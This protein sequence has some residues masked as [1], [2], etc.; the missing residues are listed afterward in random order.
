[1]GRWTRIA[2][3]RFKG[4]TMCERGDFGRNFVF[5]QDNAL[6]HVTRDT[7]AFLD[8]ND[9][10]EMDWSAMRSDMNPLDHV[11]NE[12]SIWLPDKD[13]PP[14]NLFELRQAA[15]QTWWAVRARRVWTLAESIP[16]SKV[17]VANM[18]PTWGRQDPGGP[19]VGSM[20][21]AIGDASLCAG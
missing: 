6:P 18:G 7:M 21:R 20:N 14:F 17:H 11:W 8:Q 4:I 3:Y 19:H 1:M 2:P 5:V 15:R 13:R 10:E 9:L 16:G 12:M